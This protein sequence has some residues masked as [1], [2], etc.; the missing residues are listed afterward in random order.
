MDNPYASDPK[1]VELEAVIAREIR[2]FCSNLHVSARG[3]HVI[4]SG[5]VEDYED[6]RSAM[7]AAQHVAGVHDI[8]NNLRVARTS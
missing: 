1:D 8:T 6:K 4:L 3:G 2:P 5:L 7:S